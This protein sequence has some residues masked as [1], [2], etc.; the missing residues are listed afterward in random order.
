MKPYS[1]PWVRVRELYSYFINNSLGKSVSPKETLEI[2]SIIQ[3]YSSEKGYFSHSGII[4]EALANGDYLYC[5]HSYDK[6]DFPLSE[7][8]PLYYDKIRILKIN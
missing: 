4:T 2:G 6:L 5:C 7:I 1:H 8:Y 3:F